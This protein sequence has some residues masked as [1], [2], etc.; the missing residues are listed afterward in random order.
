MP[1]YIALLRGINVGRSKRMKM[2]KL[3]QA[4]EDLGFSDIQTYIQSGNAVFRSPHR[5][6]SETMSER[7]EQMIRREFGF[8]AG[9]VSRTKEELEKIVRDNPFLKQAGVDLKTLHV[10]FLPEAPAPPAR[11]ELEN[12]TRPPDQTRL[13]GK[14]IFLRLPNGTARSSLTNNPL[15]RKFLGRGT[16]RNWNTVCALERMA[17]ELA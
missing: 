17:S 2:E 11:R 8:S 9:V 4:L 14:E 3:R 6:S 15:E 7:I 13:L 12:L 16:L 1:V 5:I 10:M